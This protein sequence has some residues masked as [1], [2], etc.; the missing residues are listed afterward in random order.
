MT[1][2]PLSSQQTRV[3]P[4]RRRE[5]KEKPERKTTTHNDDDDDDDDDVGPAL[6]P[7]DLQ[8]GAAPPPIVPSYLLD[9]ERP[10]PPAPAAPIQRYAPLS[11]A[12]PRLLYR[13]AVVPSVFAPPLLF[14][15]ARSSRAH[16]LQQRFSPYAAERV[17]RS[18]FPDGVTPVSPAV[19]AAQGTATLSSSSESL[20]SLSLSAPSASS[21][22]SS[23]FSASSFSAS[24][25]S[26]SSFSSSSS[27]S[28][29]SYMSRSIASALRLSG[30]AADHLERVHC[31]SVDGRVT[32]FLLSALHPQECG[33][34][35]SALGDPIR[36]SLLRARSTAPPRLRLST[37]PLP[38]ARVSEHSPVFT[39]AVEE[40]G[41]RAAPCLP[42]PQ[43]LPASPLG[44]LL[45]LAEPGLVLDSAP[46]Q[47]VLRSVGGAREPPVLAVPHQLHVSDASH[48]ANADEQIF[49]ECNGLR[50]LL[51]EGALTAEASHAFAVAS[52]GHIA[53]AESGTASSAAMPIPL[54]PLPASRRCGPPQDGWANSV[55]R[56]AR[57][58]AFGVRVPSFRTLVSDS[59]KLQVLD[60]LLHRLKRGGHRV[61]LYSQMT[62]M[63]T[64][65]ED[66]LTYRG[67]THIRL[68][69]TSSLADRR[70]LVEGWQNN[71]EIFVFILST[72]AGGVGINLTAADTVIFYDSD[73]NPTVDSQAMD[74]AHRLGQT[75]PVY[76]YR[77]LTKNTIEGRIMQRAKQKG[78]IQELVISGGDFQA[79]DSSHLKASEMMA[80]LME[81]EL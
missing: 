61:L 27:S 32:A 75:R 42:S 55:V 46:A 62:K 10:C 70:D 41:R 19:N 65:L 1:E 25:F 79:T 49:G 29:S 5:K 4:E 8:S 57:D 66:Y 64:I 77:L 43:L 16:L 21:A 80:L 22:S 33:A 34:A 78:V 3:Q 72:R 71:P 56:A 63:L 50:T 15:S 76:V 13:E 58:N 18:L 59:G 60:Q 74:R 81:D 26:S 9:E 73:W 20:S 28:S 14:P 30:F 36:L 23:S 54:R 48:R 17:H 39:A 45:F 44:G 37:P 38:E 53:A 67:Y 47:C 68:D 52:T 24:S 7:F 40:G 31:D 12:L 11:L 6:A 51:L 35:R 69:G 2:K